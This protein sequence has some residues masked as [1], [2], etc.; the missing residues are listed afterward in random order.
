[1][2]ETR[3][4]VT[5]RGSKTR[6]HLV[7]LINGVA[8]DLKPFEDDPDYRSMCEWIHTLKAPGSGPFA[9]FIEATRYANEP[10]A[11][12]RRCHCDRCDSSDCPHIAALDQVGLL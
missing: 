12:S 11:R 6:A 9:V 7:L 10:G 5:G 4:R 8:H 3:P 1:M 2:T